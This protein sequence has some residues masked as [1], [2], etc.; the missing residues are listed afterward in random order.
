[1]KT[2]WSEKVTDCEVHNSVVPTLKTTSRKRLYNLEVE[3]MVKM[4]R[5]TTFHTISPDDFSD[6]RVPSE[7]KVRTRCAIERV[8]IPDRSQ[9]DTIGISGTNDPIVS[10]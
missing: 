2:C 8:T 7:P 4:E 3:I 6:I 10:E 9:V 1:M 5:R